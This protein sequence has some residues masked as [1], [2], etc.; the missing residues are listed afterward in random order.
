MGRIT[1]KEI[2][3]ILELIYAKIDSRTLFS[4]GN[5]SIVDN[6]KNQIKKKN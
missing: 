2:Q 5:V 6:L 1:K 4:E 3:T